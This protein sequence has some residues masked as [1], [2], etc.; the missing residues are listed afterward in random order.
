MEFVS[1]VWDLIDFIFSVKSCLN[2]LGEQEEDIQFWKITIFLTRTH[3][4]NVI[5]LWTNLMIW[6]ITAISWKYVHALK[7]LRQ[8]LSWGRYLL[9]TEFMRDLSSEV[10]EYLG[11]TVTVWTHQVSSNLSMRYKTCSGKSD[12]FSSCQME[13]LMLLAWVKLGQK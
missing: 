2:S 8:Y 1:P 4:H 9:T 10:G 11:P 6:W 13:N 3:S 12:Y 7:F 5:K